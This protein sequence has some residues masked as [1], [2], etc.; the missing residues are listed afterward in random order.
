M[1]FNLAACTL[2]FQQ[3]ADAHSDWIACYHAPTANVHTCPRDC[4]H[5]ISL[6]PHNATVLG[7]GPYHPNSSICL[8]AIHAGVVDAELGGATHVSR[9]YPIDWS[10]SDTQSIYPEQAASGSNGH[11][12][13]SLSVPAADNVRP[14]P[15]S[16]FSWSCVHAAPF[17]DR[18][19]ALRFRLAPAICTPC[20]TRSCR[21]ALTGHWAG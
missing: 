19:S 10:G 17:H 4:L 3:F 6:S 13:T 15:Q 16:S 21:G 8:A 9:F 14:A 1:R 18:C 12:V 2:S 11:G 5:A 20:C 7:S